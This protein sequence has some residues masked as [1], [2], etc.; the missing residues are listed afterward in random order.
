M[1]SRQITINPGGG[2]SVPR[3]VVC[4][5]VEP[6]VRAIQLHGALECHTF[7]IGHASVSW[8]RRGTC[9][10][11]ALARIR[12]PFGFWSL[13]D[14]CRSRHECTWVFAHNLGYDLTLLGFWDWL[15]RGPAQLVDAVLADPPTVITVRWGR[16]LVRFVDVLNYWRLSVMDLASA[17]GQASDSRAGDLGRQSTPEERVKSHVEVIERCIL[18]MINHVA[19]TGCC[20]FRATAAGMAWATWT[21]SFLGRSLVISLD[22]RERDIARKAYLGGRVQL[23]ST[24]KCRE[25]VTVLD[26][27]SLYPSVMVDRPYPC[28]LVKRTGQ[29]R[30]ADLRSAQRYYDCVACVDLV[31][32]PGHLPVWHAGRPVYSGG[33]GLSYLAGAELALALAT[34]SVARVHAACLYQRDDLF[35]GFVRHFH[36]AKT[37]ARVRGDSVSECWAKMMLCSLY[38]KFA[39]RGHQWQAAPDVFARGHYAYWWH[40]E[41]GSP[42]PVWAR[43]IAGRVEL[44]RQG[45]EPRHSFPAIA[46]HVTA[47]ARIAMEHDIVMCGRDNFLYSDT[48]SVHCYDDGVDRLAGAGRIKPGCLGALRKVYQGADAEYYGPRHYRVGDHWCLAGIKATATEVA[49]G[50]FLQDAFSGVE[51]TLQTGALD[52]INVAQREVRLNGRSHQAQRQYVPIGKTAGAVNSDRPAR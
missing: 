31:G 48:D 34:C 42:R 35:T 18:G 9:V 38:G 26:V 12:S 52:T 14:E 33:S 43:S 6:A 37:S 30:P 11:H 2:S 8:L 13:L 40:K 39:Q 21:K 27:D 4:I 28:R 5:D 24:G 29:M 36:A 50:V 23:R 46:A 22:Q 32:A 10:D 15:S 45:P 51:R 47:A 16:R 17:T 41:Q 49:D 3:L 20:S 1:R 25:R 7:G 44:N 19:T